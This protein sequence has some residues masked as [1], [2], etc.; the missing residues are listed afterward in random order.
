MTEEEKEYLKDYHSRVDDT[1]IFNNPTAVENLKYFSHQMLENANHFKDIAESIEPKT[2][3]SKKMKKNF[4]DVAE[5]NW[6]AYID[7]TESN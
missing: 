4:E 3:I 2:D 7:I 1:N 6:L 5:A